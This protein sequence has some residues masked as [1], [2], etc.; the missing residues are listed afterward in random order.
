MSGSGYHRSSREEQLASE[1]RHLRAEVRRLT[2]RVD[3]QADQI[4]ELSANLEEVSGISSRVD[5]SQSEEAEIVSSVPASTTRSVPIVGPTSSISTS[6]AETGISWEFRVEVARDIGHFLRRAL[7]RQNRGTSGRDRLQ[8]LRSK[9]YLICRDGN[10]FEHPVK[11]R[12]RFSEVK[13]A[14]C[15]NGDWGDSVFIGLPSIRE[16]RIA[17]VI[18]GLDWPA[19]DQ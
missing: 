10:T 16:A 5:R 17:A 6:A 19:N 7:D 13:A 1:V 4:S 14:C 15:R 9:I 12:S 11:V 3:E 8:S 18:A 2:E